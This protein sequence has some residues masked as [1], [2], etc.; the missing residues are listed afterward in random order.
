MKNKDFELFYVQLAPDYDQEEYKHYKGGKYLLY[1]HKYY[2]FM[3]QQRFLFHTCIC[4]S[5][6]PLNI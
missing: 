5:S 6:P 2:K 1:K 3:Q 4:L